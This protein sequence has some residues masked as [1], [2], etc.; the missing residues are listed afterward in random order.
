MRQ[1]ISVIGSA[2]VGLLASSPAAPAFAQGFNVIHN[3]TNGS[4]GGVPGYSLVLDKKGDL[5][6]AASQGGA[7]QAGIIFRMAQKKSGWSLKPVYNFDG[8]AGQPEW[9]VTLHKGS[10]YTNASYVSVFGGACGSAMQIAHGQATLMWT[11][12]K[13]VDGCPTGNLALD[14]SGNA[15]GVTQSGGPN[16][17]GAVFE[18]SPSGSSWTETI[19]HAFAGE[20]DG[21]NPYSGLI[22][23]KSGNLYGAATRGGNS[24]CG[25]YGCGTLFELSPS[26][27]G[28]NYTALYAFGGGDDGGSPVAGLMMDKSGNLYGAT[29]SYGANGGGTVFELS[30][31]QGNWNFSVLASLTGT[32]GPVA[33]LSMD[34]L[35][36]LY[37]TNYR[38]GA[39]N[40]GSV[41][42]VSPSNGGWTYTDLYDFT[43]GSDGGY[44]GGGVTL[45]A[46][47]NLYGTTVLG[48]ADNYG[49]VWEIGK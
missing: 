7:D 49:V 28:W 19:L 36:N 13:K 4:D 22:I 21:G 48:G 11:Y 18:L 6:G 42:E 43:G 5:V 44:P 26:Q 10:I 39:D 17:W 25:G 31:S 38:D 47:G 14:K 46:E 12:T 40:Y 35:G 8:T 16:G 33:A 30:P 34:S 2:A 27:S 3:F 32:T 15:Y 1:I 9:G 20:G 41:F 45:D 29:E 24:G 23:D 37:G